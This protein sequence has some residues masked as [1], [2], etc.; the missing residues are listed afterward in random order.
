VAAERIKPHAVSWSSRGMCSLHWLKCNAAGF[1]HQGRPMTI[2]VIKSHERWWLVPWCHFQPKKRAFV[3]PAPANPKNFSGGE[4]VAFQ[5]S[6]FP[7]LRASSSDQG[8]TLITTSTRPVPALLNP[9]GP[10]SSRA[11]I[12]REGAHKIYL[13]RA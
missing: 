5:G 10:P 2:P 12:R 1:F 4:W 13:P 8:P 7:L 3:V 6:G 9:G 11:R